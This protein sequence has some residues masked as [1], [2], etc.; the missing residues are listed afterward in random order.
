MINVSNKT[1][2]KLYAAQFDDTKYIVITNIP[3]STCFEKQNYCKISFFIPID[4][5]KI[6]EWKKIANT[7]IKGI[8][9]CKL[10]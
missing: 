7:T 10:L 6:E 3:C 5:K 2:E 9:K 4:E 1:S 8:C